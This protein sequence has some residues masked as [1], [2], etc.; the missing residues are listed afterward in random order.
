MDNICAKQIKTVPFWNALEFKPN[1]R[2][3]SRTSL[4]PLDF[5][6]GLF[7]RA[8]NVCWSLDQHYC[9]YSLHK[10][11]TAFMDLYCY[12]FFFCLQLHFTAHKHCTTLYKTNKALNLILI[13]KRGFLLKYYRK[14]LQLYV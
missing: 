6:G 1:N 10:R 9:L 13:L 8:V 5:V 4:S 2:K 12:C 14:P 11:Y 7:F 3:G